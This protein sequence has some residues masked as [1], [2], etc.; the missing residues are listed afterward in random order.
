MGDKMETITE[1]CA[2]E[3][4][5]TLDDL[6]V[7][8]VGDG[9]WVGSFADFALTTPHE[10]TLSELS[11]MADSVRAGRRY[12][13]G[14]DGK[15]TFILRREPTAAEIVERAAG[16][17][18][19]L[20][21]FSV[22]MLGRDEKLRLGDFQLARCFPTDTALYAP[23]YDAGKSWVEI[24]YGG[25]YCRYTREVH[26]GEGVFADADEAAVMA[27]LDEQCE[28]MAFAERQAF[29]EA[30]SRYRGA[31][32]SGAAEATLETMAR[33]C[34]ELMAA[35]KFVRGG[36]WWNERTGTWGLGTIEE[37]EIGDGGILSGPHF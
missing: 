28:L 11:T 21:G 8:L 25:G 13:F 32:E 29:G 19:L 9:R 22:R 24:Y 14:G 23:A 26:P 34:D 2:A 17:M 15:P 20:A 7:V 18:V 5:H 37:N 4:A 1:P 35:M 12:Q 3:L 36:I 10:F 31:K 33:N 30:V 16:W 27:A 6:R